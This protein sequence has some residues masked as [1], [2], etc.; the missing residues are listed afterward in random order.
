MNS[1]YS[2]LYFEFIPYIEGSH[3]FIGAS[4]S[5]GISR[6]HVHQYAKGCQNLKEEICR[7][8]PGLRS[9]SYELLVEYYFRH[10]EDYGEDDDAFRLAH[11]IAE[12]NDAFYVDSDY[13]TGLSDDD[14]IEE[15]EVVVYADSDTTDELGQKKCG[16]V[17]LEVGKQLILDRF[18]SSG[19]PLVYICGIC[20]ERVSHIERLSMLSCC[21]HQF[22]FGCIMKWCRI[23]KSN[24]PVCRR[25]V[26][27][28]DK[29][30]L[31]L[32]N[33]I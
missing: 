20:K 27:R 21:S 6:C 33:D 2:L 24:C 4:E 8:Y 17:G 1:R 16:G 28:V 13:D 10:I 18:V 25:S 9:M 11:L 14:M 15:D 19:S 26:S 23:N 7:H 3:H 31:M 30:V 32:N 29:Y 5:S 22:C 12:E